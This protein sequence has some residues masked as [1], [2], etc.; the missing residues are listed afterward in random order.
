M[1]VDPEEGKQQAEA[2]PWGSAGQGLHMAM[3]NIIGSKVPKYFLG[4]DGLCLSLAK[5]SSGSGTCPVAIY[6]VWS[7]LGNVIW[8]VLQ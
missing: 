7:E 8:P 3:G 5:L 2:V 1:E 4:V 6:H